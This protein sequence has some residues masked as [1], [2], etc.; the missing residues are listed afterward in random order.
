MRVA[1]FLTGLV[2][3]ICSCGNESKKNHRKTDD[4]NQKE[5]L[6]R[7]ID[8][9]ESI[10]A[11]KGSK[12]PYTVSKLIS[13]YSEYRNKF[14]KDAEAGDYFLKAGDLAM[15]VGDW[16]KAVEV[17]DNFYNDY[18]EHPYSDDA[19]FQLG[20]IF[21]FQL[22]DKNKAKQ[23]YEHYFEHYGDSI[24]IDEVRARLKDL[25]L[26]EEELIKKFRKQNNLD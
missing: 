6:V 20:F 23:V 15:S 21:D 2:V 5:D 24:H 13:A 14:R 19:L 1:I 17:F 3:F 12:D 11:V 25:D 16:D 9:L 18:T 7:S 26:T 8:S 4:V 10:H 22:S